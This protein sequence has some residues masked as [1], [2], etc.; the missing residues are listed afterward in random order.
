MAMSSISAPEVAM[1]GLWDDLGLVIRQE[2]EQ[3]RR[4]LAL[5]RREKGLIL[6]GQLQPL[7]D[8]VKQKETLAV[9]LKVLAEARETL[10][11][12]VAA[13]VGLDASELHFGR[14]G[15]LAPA[16]HAALFAELR[17]EFRR[18]VRQLAVANERNGLLLESSLDYIRGSLQLFTTLADRNPVYLDSGRLAAPS[19]PIR[20]LNQRA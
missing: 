15:A 13:R 19:I 10:L 1:D 6:K 3:Y 20:V 5:L 8:L 18:L 12:R 14:L 11:S 16:T 9:E 4:L 2:V 17:D 7:L